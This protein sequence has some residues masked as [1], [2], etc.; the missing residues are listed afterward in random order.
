MTEQSLE[1]TDKDSD[2]EEEEQSDETVSGDE[3]ESSFNQDLSRLLQYRHWNISKAL[4]DRMDSIE[5]IT[6]EHQ[7]K[8]RSMQYQLTSE[9]YVLRTSYRGYSFHTYRPSDLERK[10]SDY[11][12]QTSMYTFFQKIS[13]AQPTVSHECLMNIIERVQTTFNDLLCSKCIT[14]QQYEHMHLHRSDV[15]LSYLFFVVHIE[16]VNHP[17]LPSFFRSS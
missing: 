10:S 12:Q 11:V 5:P 14:Y 6:R 4:I 15:E 9:T 1:W 3:G 7:E 16:K 2:D 8:I 13:V 17:R